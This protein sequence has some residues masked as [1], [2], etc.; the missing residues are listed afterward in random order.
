MRLEYFAIFLLPELMQLNRSV[1]RIMLLESCKS[2]RR[3]VIDHAGNKMEEYGS[4]KKWV[5]CVRKVCKGLLNF[6]S[7]T[8]GS[9]RTFN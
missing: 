4:V 9:Y 8:S 6:R 2:C 1:R 5:Q 7:A 3:A